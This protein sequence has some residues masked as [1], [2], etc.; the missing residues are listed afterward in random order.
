MLVGDYVRAL[1]QKKRKKD[2]VWNNYSK[3][4]YTSVTRMITTTCDKMDNV[5]WK[6]QVIKTNSIISFLH[7][8]KTKLNEYNLRMCTHDIT[9]FKRQRNDKYKIQYS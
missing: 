4:Y 8:K 2:K 7:K 3:K 6:K 5:E 9:I 1:P